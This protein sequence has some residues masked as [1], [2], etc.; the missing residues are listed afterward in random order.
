VTARV[1]TG[2]S[3]D[4]RTS[5][6]VP[7]RDP[8]KSP[9]MQVAVVTQPK[10]ALEEVKELEKIAAAVKTASSVVPTEALT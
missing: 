6:K 4:A 5:D 7:T 10:K 3:V 2:P 8:T 1:Q 9:R